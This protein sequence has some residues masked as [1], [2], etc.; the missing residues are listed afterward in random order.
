MPITPQTTKLHLTELDGRIGLPVEVK[1][2]RVK[3]RHLAN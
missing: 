1:S 3:F 2:S